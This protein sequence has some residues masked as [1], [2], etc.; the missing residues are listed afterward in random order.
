MN[1]DFLGKQLLEKTFFQKKNLEEK[2]AF[3]KV[4]RKKLFFPYY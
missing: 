4:S 2:H 1:L 3:G